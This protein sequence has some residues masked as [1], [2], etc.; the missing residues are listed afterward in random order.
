MAN[1][2]V[3]LAC[4]GKKS[5]AATEEERHPGFQNHHSHPETQLRKSATGLADGMS[6]RDVAGSRQTV[7]QFGWY[8]Y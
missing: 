6:W 2:T 8:W 4:S 3:A 7:A 5:W 1:H